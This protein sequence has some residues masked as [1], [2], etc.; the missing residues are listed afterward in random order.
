VL[1]LHR[2]YVKLVSGMSEE[3]LRSA[4]L[5]TEER[6]LEIQQT[7]YDPDKTRDEMSAAN[8]HYQYEDDYEE[9][10]VSFDSY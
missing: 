7:E 10:H 3:W 8:W 1:Y 6:L 9:P 5:D 2:I 4:D